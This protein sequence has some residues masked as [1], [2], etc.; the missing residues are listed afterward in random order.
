MSSVSPIGLNRPQI[1]PSSE[2]PNHAAE[3]AEAKAPPPQQQAQFYSPVS[4]VDPDT[5][6]AVLDVL[7]T[8]TGKVVQQYPSKQVVEEYRRHMLEQANAINSGATAQ[9]ADGVTA[10]AAG[11]GGSSLNASA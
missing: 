11:S 6:L 9:P 10:V 4:K 8:T 3:P 5:G 2:Q 7:D 1:A